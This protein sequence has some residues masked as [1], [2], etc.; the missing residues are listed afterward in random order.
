MNFVLGARGRLGH[1]IA[2]SL[3][4]DLVTA[5][6]RSVYAEWWHD[7]ASDLVSRFLEDR[8]S[9]VGTVYVAAGL[10]DPSRPSDE[11]QKVNYLLARN[12]IEGATKLGFRVVTFGTVME[13]VV[14]DRSANPYFAS[15]VRLGNFVDDFSVKSDLVLHVRIH[16]LFGGGLPDGFM[17]LGQMLHSLVNHSEFKMSPGTQLREYHHLDDEVA[18]I[19]KLLASGATGSIALS[20]SAPVTLKD[21][22]NYIFDT[23]KCPELLRVGALPGPANDNYGVLFE[24]PRA[25]VGMT[26]RETLPALVDYLRTCVELSGRKQE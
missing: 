16:T 15:K 1:A 22:A 18:A 25:L 13:T 5:P 21:M 26:F 4:A 3:P 17:F 8:A 9:S 10:I 14:G 24:R 2:L 23:F 6:A 12:V 11:H 19:G 7:G 20:H